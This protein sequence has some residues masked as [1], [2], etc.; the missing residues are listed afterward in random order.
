MLG[1]AVTLRR[2]DGAL[3]AATAPPYPAHLYA[4][5]ARG[6]WDAAVRLCRHV[7]DAACWA[8]LACMAIQARE[9]NTVEIALA[10]I[11]AVDKV[12]YVAHLGALDDVGRRAELA[13]FCRRPEEALA[14]LLSS[15]KIYR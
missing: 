11:D 10:A 5:V 3:L 2:A 1:G 8:A 9:L 13:L 7:K 12:Q 15:G 14:L 6:A 4:A